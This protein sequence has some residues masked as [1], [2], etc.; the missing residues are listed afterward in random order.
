MEV[1]AMKAKTILVEI[2]IVLVLCSLA[3]AEWTEPLPVTEVNTE[4]EEMPP[5]LSFDGLSLYFS[6]V[7][8]DTFYYARLFEARRQGPYGPFTSVSEVLSSG[9]QH[10][11]S[12]WVSPD[13]LRMYYFAQKESPALWQL[14]VSERASVN[15]PWLAGS[16]ISELNVLGKLTSPKLTADELIIVFTSY[17]IP[18]GLGGYDLWMAARS[19]RYSQFGPVRNLAEL[20]TAANDG[21]PYVTPDGLTLYFHSDRNGSYQ[22]FR[23][24]RKSLTEPFENIEHLSLFDTP[25]GL[26]CHPSMSS[27]GSSLYFVK[28]LGDDW[29]MRDIYVSY[30]IVDPYEVAIN[31]ILDAIAEKLDA[32]DKVN[33]ALEEEWT[34]YE[35]L[36]ELL[37]SGDYGDLKKGDIITAMQKVHSAIQHEELTKK[38][39]D[40]SI[41][42]LEDALAALGWEPPPSVSHWKFDEGSGTTAYDSVGTNDGTVYGATWTTGQI[43]GALSFDGVDDYVD[44]PYNSNLDRNASEGISLSVWFKL[45]SYPAGWNQG[46]IF[47]LFDSADAGA[48]NYLFIDKPLYGNLITWDQYPPSYGWIKSIKPDLDTWY[49]IAVVEDSSYRAIYI[50]GSLDV[51]DNTPEL[52]QGNPPDTIRIG[53]RADLAPFYFNGT[54]DD[55]MIFDIA[56]SAQE[57]QQLYNNGSA[58]L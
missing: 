23:A 51:S 50:N 55:V 16:D 47:G 34:A 22:I 11:F 53:S 37:E 54:I 6:R 15:D 30:W 44:I 33:A 19:D 39:L 18:G 26:S 24:T 32:L 48:K 25:Q 45:N 58:G 21:G 27:D 13:N 20:N 5:F 9:Y 56:L 43:N 42:K 41:E 38:T 29:S 1:K 17:D 46:P 10:V 12:P 57:I 8:T 31:S 7:R 49:H 3:L 36:Q 4:Y 35:A 28:Q 40:R 14:K 2:L 52:Y